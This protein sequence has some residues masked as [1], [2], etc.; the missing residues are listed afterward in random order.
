MKGLNIGSFFKK[1]EIRDLGKGNQFEKIKS[2]AIE[3]FLKCENSLEEIKRAQKT[4]LLNVIKLFDIRNTIVSL[5]RNGFIKSLDYESTLKLEL[6]PKSVETVGERTKLRKQRLHEIAKNE[7]KI[8]IELFSKFFKYLGQSNLC[9]TLNESIN[10]QRNKIQTKL[11]KIA[12]TN[13]REDIENMPNYNA[14]KIEENNKT[15]DIVEHIL[16]FNEENKKGEG[17]KIL[18]PDQM[19]SRYPISIKCRK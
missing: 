4:V 1:S 17:L 3:I 5:F 19:L 12:L 6:K 9:E 10:T 16:Y 8:N 7:K 15:I 11:V 14:N 18:T 13:F 2:R